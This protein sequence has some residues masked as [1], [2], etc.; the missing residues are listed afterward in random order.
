MPQLLEVSMF[1]IDLGQTNI[2]SWVCVPKYFGTKCYFQNGTVDHIPAFCFYCKVN[3]AE[4][5][6]FQFVTEE[7]SI[8]MKIMIPHKVAT[9]S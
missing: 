9:S 2:D 6:V 7:C 8:T 4:G 3:E 1:A 5:R